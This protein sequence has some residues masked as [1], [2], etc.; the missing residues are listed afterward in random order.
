M[1]EGIARR[2]QRDGRLPADVFFASAGVA[3]NDGDPLSGETR[4]V[5]ERL[6]VEA[7]GHAK[8]L[9]RPMISKADAVFGMTRSH[10]AGARSLVAAEPADA[11]KVEPLDPR[12]DIPDPIGLGQD[13]YDALAERLMQL[14]PRRLEGMLS[15]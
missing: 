1:A 3:A 12:G 9:T 5:L 6:G 15:S 13:A 8:R 14:L 11:A 4:T 7:S 2:L 10:V